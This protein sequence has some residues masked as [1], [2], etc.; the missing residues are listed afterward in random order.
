M[1]VHVCVWKYSCDAPPTPSPCFILL[2]DCNFMFSCLSSLSLLFPHTTPWLQLS[3]LN[4]NWCVTCALYYHY[5]LRWDDQNWLS[6]I[7]NHC[8]EKNESD[9]QN[10]NNHTA[11][12][13]SRRWRA[14]E[15]QESAKS[16][17]KKW[18]EFRV[19]T[20]ELW[21][22]FQVSFSLLLIRM[23]S[24]DTRIQIM[25]GCPHNGPNGYNGHVCT[26][27]P[28]VVTVSQYYHHVV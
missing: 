18:E 28:A 11:E 9:T 6:S 4:E 13:R 20:A 1:C 8:Q 16:H 10:S 27:P 5:Y 14:V 3:Y 12:L 21:Q 23:P 17:Q 25:S 7:H 24:T 15:I 2:G 19:V 26:R 22:P